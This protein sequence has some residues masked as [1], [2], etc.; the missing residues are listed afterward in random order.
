M[1]FRSRAWCQ[2]LLHRPATSARSKPCERCGGRA[3]VFEYRAG[4]N[5]QGRERHFCDACARRTLWVPKTPSLG[6][7]VPTSADAVV[8]P[9]EVE[10]IIFSG[11][12]WQTLVLREVGGLRRLPLSVGYVEATAVWWALKREPCPRPLTH[13]ALVNTVTALG[14]T[15]RRADV[16]A[17]RGD[18]YFAQLRLDR[19]GTT[20]TIDMRPSDALLVALRA[21][22]P[23][24]F[25]EPLLAADSVSEPEP[26]EQSAAPGRRGR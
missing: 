11:A 13:Q 21:D 24:L 7:V 23:F 22:V 17:R 25:V 5:D 18:T 4:P 3:T 12:D 20:S 14:A 2:S 26:S 9:V 19:D 15:I 10:R 8:V 16:V 6:E 1:L